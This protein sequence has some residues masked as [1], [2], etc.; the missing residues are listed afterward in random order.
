MEAVH[1]GNI[2]IPIIQGET[3]PQGLAGKIKEVRIKKLDILAEPTVENLGTEN[4]SIIEIGIPQND[5]LNNAKVND[6][7]NLILILDSTREIDVGTVVG[8]GIANII[9]EKGILR[10]ELTDGSVINAGSVYDDEIT[11]EQINKIITSANEKLQEIDTNSQEI[12]TKYNTYIEDMNS[13]ESNV[14]NIQTNVEQ[15]QENIINSETNIERIEEEFNNSKEQLLEEAQQLIDTSIDENTI[16]FQWDGKSSD[17]NPNNIKL[18]QKIIDT[19]F[20]KENVLVICSNLDSSI[21]TAKYVI[22]KKVVEYIKESTTRS[23]FSFYGDVNTFINNTESLSESDEN[24]TNLEIRYMKAVIEASKGEVLKVHE[25][26]RV[27]GKLPKY[28]PT[29]ITN[30]YY[31]NKVGQYT[32]TENYQPVNKK[33][34]DDTIVDSND[35]FFIYNIANEKE[36]DLETLSKVFKKHRE[37]KNVLIFSKFHDPNLSCDLEM[38]FYFPKDYNV[39]PI[40]GNITGFYD[41]NTNSDNYNNYEIAILNYSQLDGVVKSFSIQRARK[42]IG[43]NYLSTTRDYTVPYMPLYDGS[44]ATKKYVDNCINNLSN[45]IAQ[46][47]M[48]EK[49]KVNGEE[50]TIIDKS[51]NIVVPTDNNQLTNGAEYQNASQVQNAISEVLADYLKNTDLV[52]ITNEEIDEIFNS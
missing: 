23:N 11:N 13:V 32:P 8:K 37:G 12:D 17:D 30:D 36:K 21:Q 26:D 4:E 46:T 44:P 49:I 5:N 40:Y 33:Y 9:I 41:G 22:N 2:K 15:I 39:N 50:Q 19:A 10:F 25:I 29:N 43:R 51:V 28:L 24:G 35:I 34:V 7:G 38:I 27:G 1:I 20:E 16:I 31:K 3:G 14:S 18:W 45:T 42:K 47:N 48:L 6:K 52:E